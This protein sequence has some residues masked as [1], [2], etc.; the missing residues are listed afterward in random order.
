MWVTLSSTRIRQSDIRNTGGG[1]Q[2]AE[3]LVTAC[4]GAG[5]GQWMR[6]SVGEPENTLPALASQFLE[7]FASHFD[8]IQWVNSSSRGERV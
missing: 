5:G 3:S 1:D 8:P 4:D 7:G 6:L 2:R